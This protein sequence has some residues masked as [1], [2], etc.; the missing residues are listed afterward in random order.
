VKLPLH[1]LFAFLMGVTLVENLNLWPSYS[2]FCV[3]W[4]L[5]A[6]NEERLRDP[7]PWHGALTL[8]QMWYAILSGKISPVYIS[9]H[10]NEAAIRA[11][12][13]EMNRRFEQE[14]E[15]LKERQEAA[16]ALSEFLAGGTTQPEDVSGDLETKLPGNRTINPMAIALL[17][18]QQALGQV[19]SVVRI[20]RSVLM[21]DESYLAFIIWNSCLL[22]G[23]IFLFVPWHFLVRCTARILVWTL[24]GP[25]MKLVDVYVLPRIL[26]TNMDKDEALQK[27]A[28]DQLQNL[29]VAKEALLRKKE[30]I[31]KERALKQY[32]FGKFSVKVP[33][34]KDFRYRDVPLPESYATS[35]ISY[36]EIKVK[37]RSHGQTLQGDMVP[38]WGDAIDGADVIS[39]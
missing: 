25:W 28:R 4:L 12:Q 34:F 15:Q 17:P 35:L 11:Y 29:G 5:A 8:A 21:W 27:L 18:V 13:E 37:K 24:L 31:M 32:M 19:C 2:L 9:E 39:K 26:G 38:I 3:S 6:T 22:V 36:D 14:K 16:K 1:S 20:I 33:R 23:F 10:E 7:S 30:D